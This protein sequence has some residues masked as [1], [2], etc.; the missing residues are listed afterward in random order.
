LAAIIVGF[1]LFG[2]ATLWLRHQPAART[3][4]ETD[5]ARERAERLAKLHESDAKALSEYTWVDRDAGVVGLP[6]DRAI[7]LALPRLKN[8]PVRQGPPIPPPADTNA[9]PADATSA[10]PAAPA[11]ATSPPSN[12][13]P[14]TSP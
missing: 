2:A 14:Q 9:P 6:L 1:L 3:D 11:P 10:P 7:E 8:K 12:L 5:R 13:K 4:L